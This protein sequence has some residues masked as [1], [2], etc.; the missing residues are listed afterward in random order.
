M[1]HAV[2]P[3]GDAQAEQDELEIQKLLNDEGTGALDF[4]NRDLDPG[5]KADDAVDYEDI[6]D[7]DLADL[8][9]GDGAIKPADRDDEEPGGLDDIMQEGQLPE[10]KEEADGE[11]DLYDDL[12]GE[13]PSSEIGQQDQEAAE[14]EQAEALERD[15]SMSFEF[16]EEEKGPQS[17]AT[18]R[19]TSAP[20][21]QKVPP[22]Q[23][24]P[25]SFRDVNFGTAVQDEDEAEDERLREQK[26]LLA[27]S[28]SDSNLPPAP[29]ENEEELLTSM[30]PKF[31]RNAVPRFMDLI[32][33]KKA[34]YLGKTPLKPP[35]VVQ[36]TKLSLD[37]AQDQERSFR[38]AGL[39]HPSKHL[40]EADAEQRGLVLIPDLHPEGEDEDKDDLLETLSDSEEVGG[41]SWQDLCILCQDWDTSAL[42]GESQDSLIDRDSGKGSRRRS[43]GQFVEDYSD[44]EIDPA[45]AKRRKLSREIKDLFAI[46]QIALPSLEDPEAVTAKL[47]KRVTLDLN[48][49]HLLIDVQP[50]HQA[51]RRR[52]GGDVRRGV[53][54]SFTKDLTRRYNISNDEAYDLLKENHQSKIRSTIGNLTVEHSMPAVRL[55]YPYYKVKLQTRE[56]RSYHRP[57]MQ[58][59]PNVPIMF[60]KPRSLKRKHFKG[61]DAMSM[62]TSTKD[63]SLADNSSVLL[64][65]Y[66]EE[67][68]TMMSNFGMGSRLINYYRRKNNEDTSRPKLDIGETAVLMPQDKSPFSIFGNVEPGTTM[69][70][71]YNGMFR[72]PIF[73][74]E[75]RSTDFLVVRNTTGVDGS[76]FYMRNIE[77]LCVVGQQFPS[78]DV[79]GPHS[80]KVTTAS[81][82][83]LKMI[84]FRQI[85]RKNPPR[86]SV[87]EVTKHFP[88]TTDIQNR[89][90]MK[91][92][93]QFSKEHKE[94]EMRSG[95]PIPDEASLRSMVKPEDVCLLEAMQVGQRHLQD[96]G[97]SKDDDED[98]DD[99][100]EGQSLEQQLA[101]WQ[102]TRNFINA[103][104]GKAMLQ[105]HGDGDP[106]GRGEAFSFIRTSMKGGFKAVGESVEDK[107]DAKKLKELG[108]HSYNVARQQRAY[109][110]SI[111]RIW[112][113]QK[114]SLSSNVEHS[115]MDID[116]EHHDEAEDLF[117]G[118]PTPRSEAPTPS[119]FARRDDETTSQFSR[120]STA[121]QSG[122]VLRIT[123][124]MRD[125]YG[126]VER[127]Q[128]VIRDP[129]VIRQYLRRRHEIEAE[130][131]KLTDLRPT[132]DAEQDRRNRKL[133]EGE[134]ARLER[135]KDRRLARDKQKGLLTGANG[136]SPGSPSSPSNVQTK[137]VGTQRKCANCGQVGHIKTNKK[138]CPMLNGTMQQEDAFGE[139][140]FSSM[141][142]S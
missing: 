141:G 13:A 66:S 129:R 54:G 56:A 25:P 73:R 5:E 113:A 117:I 104:Q 93:M 97:Y 124:E 107:L 31:E 53:S 103:C 47:A 36:P 91:E 45:A 131:L 110:E 118:G 30:W 132:G 3:P 72:A 99:S 136:K 130:T 98:D 52:L 80:R 94:W 55:Q 49:P 43:F 61:K 109:E 33:P 115:D 8:D 22:R 70:T 10:V 127:V 46:P 108:G 75:P 64:L 4:F 120:F 86:I 88:D 39:A 81:K 121:S 116:D 59:H 42:D 133:L 96:A 57:S 17:S 101:P 40:R 1:P 106:S 41:V 92:F 84:S 119:A 15:I 139:S 123:R 135:N 74:H 48:D 82:N 100:K 122:K 125:P 102:T 34:H 134:L 51:K 62:F 20:E 28:M 2:P 50:A 114:T 112:E 9:E 89:Q 76:S 7:D 58:F 79:P 77:N 67:C 78:V 142:A 71:I 44:E 69:P 35:K 26:A 95:E 138:L 65:E 137:S 105:L 14:K 6:D 38:Q 32:P 111:A 27:M 18:V 37:I 60:S 140:A 11:P 16:D 12:F 128:D 85:R 126:R 29:P 21:S 87:S 19:E 23:E 68:P 63:L 24:E 90:K 83:R